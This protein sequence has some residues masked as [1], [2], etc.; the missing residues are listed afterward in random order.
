M[1]CALLQLIRCG[2]RKN[3]SKIAST[4]IIVAGEHITAAVPA[5]VPAYTAEATTV[6]RGFLCLLA[7]GCCFHLTPILWTSACGAAEDW[8]SHCEVPAD[9][10]YALMERKVLQQYQEG[11]RVLLSVSEVWKHFLVSIARIS[12]N[13]TTVP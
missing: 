11:V 5:G 9:L 1:L 3:L 12:T 10:Y 4:A 6:L 2:A 8:P 7:C 13:T